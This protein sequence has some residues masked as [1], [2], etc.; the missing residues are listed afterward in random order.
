[1]EAISRGRSSRGPDDHIWMRARLTEDI[2][3]TS[4]FECARAM[5]GLGMKTL[6]QLS[7]TLKSAR[8]EGKGRDIHCLVKG[9]V[10]R[11]LTLMKSRSGRYQDQIFIGI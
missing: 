8:N 11:K 9:E 6:L 4:S 7:L 1:M 3:N 10:C 5:D 2:M